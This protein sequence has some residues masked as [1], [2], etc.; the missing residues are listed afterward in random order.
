MKTMYMHTIC[1]RPGLYWPGEQIC[2]MNNYSR[3]KQPSLARSLKQI[4]QEQH[5]TMA[6]RHRQ[7]FESKLADYHYVRVFVP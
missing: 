3:H 1:G 2:Y 7:G 6:W 4:R 5:A